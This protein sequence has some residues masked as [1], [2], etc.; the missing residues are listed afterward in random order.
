[1]KSFS[2]VIPIHRD[3]SYSK[4]KVANILNLQYSARMVEVLISHGG[5][6]TDRIQPLSEGDPMIRLIHRKESGKTSQLNEAFKECY[7]DIIL[8]TDVDAMMQ[9]NCLREIDKAFE[10]PDVAV[11][12]TWTYPERCTIV[13][14]IYWYIANWLRVFEAKILTA[15]HV[16]GCCLAFRRSLLRSLPEDVIADDVYIPFLANF[17]GKRTV[18]L[19]STQVAE[20]RQPRSVG[21]FMRHKTRK[22]NAVLRELLRFLYRIPDAS[23]K[24]KL[25]Y[26]ARLIQFTI[27]TPTVWLSYPWYKQTSKLRKVL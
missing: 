18:Y 16:S 5:A 24:W 14:R 13:D 8:I 1:M 4:G 19:R 12:G 2:I 9:P 23:A 10:D 21:S 7:G 22:G 15:S 25:I 11:V 20:I 17:Q 3:A 6:K 26:L 27:L